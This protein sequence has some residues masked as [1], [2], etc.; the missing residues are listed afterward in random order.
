[1]GERGQA[2]QAGGLRV[3]GRFCAWGRRVPAL[4][5][6]CRGASGLQNGLLVVNMLI[7]GH[8]GLAEQ[9]ASC[10]LPTVLQSCWR[11]GQ[12]TGCPHAMLALRVINCF[13]EHQ[14]PL[15]TAGRVSPAHPCH[16]V[17]PQTQ[18]AGL[19]RLPGQSTLLA[20]L[21][22][23]S[24]LDPCV[25]A[26]AGSGAPLDLRDMRMLLGGLRDGILSKDMVVALERQLCGEGPVLAGEAAQLLQDH[27]CFRL[28]LHS[29][30]LLG[31][32]KAM[33]L[34]ILRWVQVALVGVWGLHSTCMSAG[35]DVGGHGACL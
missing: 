35:G 24:G 17:A 15:E 20:P 31:V 6:P 12:S 13:A 8:R 1:M 33:S 34:S 16:A 29:F 32:E 2:R 7:D 3:Q 14:L 4:R 18:W 22:R 23:V 5:C 11:D 10:D 9:L 21:K 19:P 28:L 30:E 26:V 27:R 25:L